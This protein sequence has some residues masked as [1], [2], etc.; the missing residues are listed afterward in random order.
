[1][2]VKYLII[3]GGISGL[4]F[5][6][7]KK[8]DDYL[9]L[10]K[11][12]VL[13]GLCQ[14]FY[15]NGFVFDVAG[16]FFHFHSDETRAYYEKLMEGKTQVT[17]KKCAKVYYGG[18]Y[19]DA[20]FQYNIHQLPRQEFIE[21]LTDLY[22]ANC[23]DG[24]IPF[25]EFVRKKYGAGIANKFLI[26]YNEKLYA[27]KMNE[28]ERDSM[29]SFL[30]KLDFGMLMN[31]YKGSTGKTYNDTFRY[32][33]NGC[34]EIINA[35]ASE[36]DPNRIHLGEGVERIDTKE[37]VVYTASDTY[38]YEYLINTAPFNLFTKMAGLDSQESLNYNQVL[39]LNIGFDKG[40]IDK[41]VSW[42]YYPGDQ[43]FYR[44]G[45]YNNIAGTDKLSIYVEIGYK[46]NECIDVETALKRTLEDLRAVNVIDTHQV[47][48]YQPYI[49]N[50]GYVHITEKGKKYTIETKK[51]LEQQNTYMIG[52]YAKWEYSAMD[53]SLEQAFDLAKRI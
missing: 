13:G 40:S 38:E 4:A 33:I 23:P 5:A 11:D 1:M 16:H 35:L 3:G 43:L 21:C 25:D 51:Q 26:P 37:R 28:L 20:P 29:G 14:S 7:Q 30:P 12:N 45:F 53:D 6:E 31:F 24:S 36:L 34:V 9:I 42:V 18:K 32:P 17:A 8:N 46:A 22:Y 10:E 19:M 41:E 52:R 49:I 39:V 2:K 27:C 48:A 15:K 50:P 44:V 47:L